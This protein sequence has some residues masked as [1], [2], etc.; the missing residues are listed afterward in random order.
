MRKLYL[1]ALILVALSATAAQA[2][3]GLSLRWNRCYGEL[4]AATN[5]N[6]ACNTDA[7]GHLLVGSFIAPV[8]LSQVTRIDA[9]IDLAASAADLPAWWQFTGCRT[10]SLGMN[11]TA[12]PTNLVCDDWSAGLASASGLTYTVGTLGANTSRIT[13]STQVAPGQA[14]DLTAFIS[15][16]AFN[17]TINSLHT[18]SGTVCGG[19]STPMCIALNSIQLQSGAGPTVLTG[20]A[21]GSNSHCVTW[22]GGG[23]APGA[24]VSSCPAALTPARNTT[25]GAVKTLY[26]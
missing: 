23:A 22:Q 19:C 11:A 2:A 5:N 12:S 4:G 13:L 15:Y 14:Q 10:G 16:F 24:T 3:G 8:A 21:D 6:F 9:V 1:A 18:V 25:W 7:N 20:P 26:R 17:V